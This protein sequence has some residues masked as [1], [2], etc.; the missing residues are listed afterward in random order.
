MVPGWGRMNL[1]GREIGTKCCQLFHGLHSL[2]LAEG[3]WR[4]IVTISD[5]QKG[6]ALS[7][8][9]MGTIPKLSWPFQL[10]VV[11]QQ[12]GPLH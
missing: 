10:F 9:V 6:S 1:W 3:T 11:F 7:Y 4:Q 5:L 12:D 8:R 2:A